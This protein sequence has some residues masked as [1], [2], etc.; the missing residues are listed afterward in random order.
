MKKRSSRFY[1]TLRTVLK[2]LNVKCFIFLLTRAPS[3]LPL[4]AWCSCAAGR[5]AVREAGSSPGIQARWLRLRS[6][7]VPH[8]PCDAPKTRGA[9]RSPPP[10]RFWAPTEGSQT[11]K[12]QQRHNRKPCLKGR[13]KK[14][15]V[16][17]ESIEERSDALITTSFSS[18][19]SPRQPFAT[20]PQP[21]QKVCE[22]P[23]PH[24]CR[25]QAC[26]ASRT[27]LKWREFA[28]LDQLFEIFD[29]VLHSLWLYLLHMV[30][31]N[32]KEQGK[33]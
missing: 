22:P 27:R 30:V 7:S 1:C 33:R 31:Y 12:R 15:G 25:A 5:A 19:K 3:P 28:V 6:R 29:P 4:T 32:L 9:G 24:R 20:L 23:S 18:R 17:F 2:V 10:A 8:P 11:V 21:P 13:R 26:R 16:H 14:R